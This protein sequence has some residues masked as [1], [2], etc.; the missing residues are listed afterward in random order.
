MH[1]E[2]VACAQTWLIV[3]AKAQRH[4]RRGVNKSWKEAGTFMSDHKG[5]A[6]SSGDEVAR[7]MRDSLA[8]ARGLIERTQQALKEVQNRASETDSGG[9]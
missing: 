2:R 1:E 6:A 9:N 4:S 7:M 8:R 5:R 3:G